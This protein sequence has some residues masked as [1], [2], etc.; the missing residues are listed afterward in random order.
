M[1]NVLNTLVGFA[2][3]VRIADI[4]YLQGKRFEIFFQQEKQVLDLA[5]GDFVE[6]PY[7]M[8]LF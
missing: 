7:F 4:A 1:K 5:S 8:S 6:C 2:T 3:I